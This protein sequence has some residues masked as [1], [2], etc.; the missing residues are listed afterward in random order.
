[1]KHAYPL[2][3]SLLLLLPAAARAQDGPPPPQ[4]INAKARRWIAEMSRMSVPPPPPPPPPAPPAPPAPPPP[5]P[6]PP[7]L[8]DSPDI[9]EILRLVAADDEVVSTI[10]APVTLDPESIDGNLRKD[11]G[12]GSASLTFRLTGPRGRAEVEVDAESQ[13]DRW[14]ILQLDVEGD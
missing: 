10:G 2:A 3:L 9:K 13:N 6:P 12:E 8:A 1:M 14:E 5:P 11:D 7:E 4:P